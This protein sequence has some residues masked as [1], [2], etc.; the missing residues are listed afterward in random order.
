M[1]KVFIQEDTLTNIANAIR[2]KDGTTEPIAPQNMADAISNLPEG[3]ELP[4]EAYKLS[5]DVNSYFANN[6][7]KWYIDS[8]GSRIDTS[9]ITQAYSLFTGCNQYETIPLKLIGCQTGLSR[10]FYNCSK[11][12]TPPIMENI[13]VNSGI[14]YMFASCSSLKSLPEDFGASWDWSGLHNSKGAGYGVFH[15]CQK[16]KNVPRS[17]ISQLYN[18]G[19]ANGDPIYE[20]TFYNCNLLEKI[21]GLAV[22]RISVNSNEFLSTFSGCNILNEMTFDT[23]ED[24]TP[25][26]A[27]WKNQTIYMQCGHGNLLTLLGYDKQVKNDAT[28][29]ALKNDPEYWTEMKEYSHYTHRSAVNTINSLPDTSAYLATNGG[30]NTIKFYESSGSLTD[31]GGIGTLTEEEIAVATAKG[32][33]VSFM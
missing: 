16:L 14:S 12:I 1:S 11:L 23:N 6:K 15:Q 9:G 20:N 4:E 21:E 24:G 31:E 18:A 25:L 29:Q 28:Y 5:G 27:S 30:T 7:W 8:L 22:S 17:F 10:M 13:T 19:G 3:G 2:E 33:T 26:I 32:W